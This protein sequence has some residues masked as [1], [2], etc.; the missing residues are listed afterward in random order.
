MAVNLICHVL[1]HFNGGGL[2]QKGDGY[3]FRWDSLSHAVEPPEE[4]LLLVEI[5][6]LNLGN[7]D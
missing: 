6:R 2:H 5:V 1:W 4:N 7:Y 3:I